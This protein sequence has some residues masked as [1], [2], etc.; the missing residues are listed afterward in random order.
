MICFRVGVGIAYARHYTVS[1]SSISPKKL[2]IT[3]NVIRKVQTKST[4]KP[5]F[6]FLKMFSFLF[7]IYYFFSSLI[8]Y[9]AG[10]TMFSMESSSYGFV[11]FRGAREP[12]V[13]VGCVFHIF[14]RSHG[15][16]F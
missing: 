16:D 8:T 9:T 3:Q 15:N 14:E 4:H 2:L 6:N 10:E 11:Y 5:N 7:V 1:Q 12:L 13:V